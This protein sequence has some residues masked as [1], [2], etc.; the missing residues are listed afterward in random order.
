MKN[1]IFLFLP[2]LLGSCVASKN[3][4]SVKKFSPDDLRSD[5]GLFRNI[6][7]DVHPGL[8]WFTPKDSMDY[9]FEKGK[10]R[11]TDSLSEAQF[12]NV[13]S[14]VVAQIRCGH[15]AVRSSKRASRYPDTL[16][17][18]QF[19]LVLKIWKD[20]AVVAL[21]L[22]RRDTVIKRGSIITHID[23][24]PMQA[25]VD[26]LFQY[27]P[28][29]GYNLTH[30][31]QTLSNRGVFS[32]LYLSVFGH[33]SRFVVRF[34]DTAGQTKTA[35]VPLYF[36]AR[37][38]ARR[39]GP[40]SPSPRLKK[41]ERKR[42]SLL[43]SRSLR[44]DSSLQTGFMDLS[45]FAK[46]D[47]LRR[48]FAS[49][50]KKL[51]AAGARHLVIDLRYNG[52]GSVINSNLLTKYIASQPFKIADSLYALKKGARHGA[53]Q[54]DRFWNWLFLVF[55]TRKEKD[56]HYHFNFF[57]NRYFKPKKKHHFGGQVYI[58]T[59][60]NTFSAATLFAQA[61]Q[62]QKNVKIIGEETG[63][64]AYGN[65]AWLI[66]DVTLP[67]TKVRFRL[68]L[69]RLVIDKDLPKGWGV[70]PHVPAE[71]TVKDILRNADFKTEKAIQLIREY[72]AAR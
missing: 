70:M 60:G 41:R 24:K 2:L 10:A 53:Y 3:N 28:A 67:L 20:T 27:L 1:L 13:L 29:D 44:I 11:L 46:P 18:R 56:G 16:R 22:L 65:N 59:G 23:G 6:L 38:T 17:N 50:F 47:K 62:A 35:L 49:S 31:Y 64:G 7:E 5:Y 14:Y 61:V 15:T 68:P 4:G 8:Y 36:P 39:I 48:F 69:F 52:G 33:R 21:N 34:L 32:Y 45:S 63:G 72:N 58:L 37:D 55:M 30:K 43:A 26:S 66:P 51:E 71:P 40:A 54:E 12:R 25:I 19:P 57:E 42:L 9:F